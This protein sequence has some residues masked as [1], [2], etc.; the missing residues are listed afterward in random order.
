MVCLHSVCFQHLTNYP[1]AWKRTFSQTQSL[2]IYTGDKS[3]LPL[4][5][6]KI[7]ACDLLS[8]IFLR[9]PQKRSCMCLLRIR[10]ISAGKSGVLS[11]IRTRR[12]HSFPRRL[13]SQ[14]LFR[15]CHLNSRNQTRRGHVQCRLPRHDVTKKH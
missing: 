5:S 12:R 7:A 4:K 6:G 9:L 3:V 15:E 13:T 14:R 1:S 11:Q 8:T 10:T 2:R